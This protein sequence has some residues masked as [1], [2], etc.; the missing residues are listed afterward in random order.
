MLKYNQKKYLE[1]WVGDDDEEE[2]DVNGI[3]THAYYADCRELN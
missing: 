3:A 1:L 2:E